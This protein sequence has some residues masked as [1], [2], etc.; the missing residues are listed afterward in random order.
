MAELIAKAKT[1]IVLIDNYVDVGTLNILAKKQENVKVQIYTVK[2]A[3]LSPTDINNF[4]QQYPALSVNYT[5]EFHD[6]FL[7]ID[8]SWGY[9][10]GASLKDAGK[11]CFA[12]N[13]IEDWENIRDILKRIKKED[14]GGTN[15]G[16]E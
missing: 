8:E 2:R 3:K 14:N 9:H 1:E 15:D 13:R 7:I 10:I 6:R 16:R 5:E 12:I 4:N 11:K